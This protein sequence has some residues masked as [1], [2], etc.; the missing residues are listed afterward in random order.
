[1][2]VWPPRYCKAVAENKRFRLADIIQKKRLGIMA[3]TRYSSLENNSKSDGILSEGWLL[4]DKRRWRK[5]KQVFFFFFYSTLQCREHGGK[6]TVFTNA[7]VIWYLLQF[8]FALVQDEQAKLCPLLFMVAVAILR[9]H[10]R[11][12]GFFFD[13]PWT[14][15]LLSGSFQGPACCYPSLVCARNTLSVDLYFWHTTNP[16]SPETIW[17]REFPCPDPE[18]LYPPFRICILGSYNFKT[19][20]K[21]SSAVTQHFNRNNSS[22]SPRDS[23]YISSWCS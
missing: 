19:A 4:K 21:T 7:E 3:E 16:C 8:V 11:N 13:V 10:M 12:Q 23:R 20:L 14:K 5:Y 9:L 1:M 17:C 18:M 15:Q 6:S 22:V 2:E